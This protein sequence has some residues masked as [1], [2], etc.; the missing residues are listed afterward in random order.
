MK[1]L[2]RLI[3]LIMAKRRTPQAQANAKIT[4]NVVA[5][6]PI[7]PSDAFD[8]L[9]ELKSE[10]ANASKENPQTPDPEAAFVGPPPPP[11]RA[12][13]IRAELDTLVVGQVEA[14]ERLSLLL[15]MH[16]AW[17]PEKYP[18]QAPPNGLIIG[19]TGSGKTFSIQVAAKFLRIPFLVVDSTTLVPA[20]AQNGNTIEWVYDQLSALS[21]DP[22][23]FRSSANRQTERA[24]PKAIVFFDEFDKISFRE[25]D[26]N[27][28]WKGDIQRMLLKFVEG[29][30]ATK[31]GTAA[32]GLLVLVGGAFVG[33]D[34]P[35]N[36][37]KRRPEVASL[38]RLAPKR[39]IV[40]DDVVNFGFMP[41][42]V[43]R[44]PAII[45][46]E[47]LPEDALLKILQHPQTSPLL[48]WK[49]HFEGL[50]KELNFSPGF[51]AAAAKRA[52]AV[53]M[54]ARALQQIVFPALSRRAYAFEE[55]PES[56]IEVTEAILEYKE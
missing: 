42:L 55:S 35:E 17:N 9:F 30:S 26:H 54:G 6:P 13:Q 20:G 53:Q 29:Q 43:A 31:Q 5:P 45:Q 4:S 12:A 47:A 3:D 50:G 25:D 1:R 2:T 22:L 11:L 18:L 8:S 23:P 10:R 27:K 14:K 51:M 49:A 44:L 21:P 36:I 7:S 52:A 16:Q 41:E 33:I 38:L 34:G 48:V 37:R 56:T 32:R 40:A 19:P 24:Q 15:S 28:R 46:Y 39:T